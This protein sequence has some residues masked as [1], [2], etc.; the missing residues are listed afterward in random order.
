MP[1][2]VDGGQEAAILLEST[3]VGRFTQEQEHQEAVVLFESIKHEHGY[4]KTWRDWQ[5]SMCL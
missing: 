5:R 3:E 1:L 4:R 2:V